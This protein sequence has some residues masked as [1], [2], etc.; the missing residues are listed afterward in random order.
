MFESD[1]NRDEY[2]SPRK[3]HDYRQQV[4]HELEHHRHRRRENDHDKSDRH[5]LDHIQPAHTAQN[6][7]NTWFDEDVEEKKR[8]HSNGHHSR[9]G[10]KIP[11][12][13]PGM[14]AK[15]CSFRFLYICKRPKNSIS[16][17]SLLI[18]D[19]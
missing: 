10:S 15:S 17:E 13:P 16:I 11:N 1:E 9:H 5:K 3:K 18:I 19:F 12:I 14:F 8:K 4:R 2:C 7:R 6:R